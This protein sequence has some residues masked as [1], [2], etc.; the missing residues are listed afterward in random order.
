M[1]TIT[2][3]ALFMLLLC[4]SF[5]LATPA[6]FISGKIK[7]KDKKNNDIDLGSFEGNSYL[8]I[9]W[10]TTEDP[11]FGNIS[12]KEDYWLDTLDINAYNLIKKKKYILASGTDRKNVTCL[13]NATANINGTLQLHMSGEQLWN[14]DKDEQLFLAKSS[15]VN[16]KKGWLTNGNMKYRHLFEKLI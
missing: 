16:C 5:A 12:V 8:R 9:R 4:A 2:I 13:T 11:F 1:K 3:T 10:I 7:G 14:N 15:Y 6:E